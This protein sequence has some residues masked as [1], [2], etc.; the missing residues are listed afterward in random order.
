MTPRL[1]HT[2]VRRSIIV[3]V[4]VVV[5]RVFGLE[6]RDW[7]ARPVV[8]IVRFFTGNVFRSVTGLFFACAPKLRAEVEQY[9]GRAWCILWKYFTERPAQSC[10]DG[11]MW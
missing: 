4:V 5:V 1:Y 10:F 6:N 3:V 8:R 11:Y 7:R 2:R 9:R